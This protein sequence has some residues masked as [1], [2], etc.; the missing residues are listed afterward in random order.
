MKKI[1]LKSGHLFHGDHNS[2]H[3]SSPDPCVNPFSKEWQPIED[4]KDKIC[5]SQESDVFRSNKIVKAY[6]CTW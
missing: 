4:R 1:Q 2:F 6:I 5:I 3:Y